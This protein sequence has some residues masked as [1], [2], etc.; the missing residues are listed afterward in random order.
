[1]S[2]P[3]KRPAG[4]SRHSARSAVKLASKTARSKVTKQITAQSGL[5]T[6]DAKSV[7]HTVRELKT[8]KSKYGWK[9]SR[10]LAMLSS[11]QGATILAMM[12]VMGW[13]Q[14]SVRGFLAGVVRKRLKLNL[15][16][17]KVDGGRVYRITDGNDGDSKGGQPRHRAS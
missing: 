7:Q 8:D 1:M 16:S 2:K 5:A 9:Q 4:R 10:V 15:T 6:A 3:T 12:Q 14:H 13:Q 17:E 11:P